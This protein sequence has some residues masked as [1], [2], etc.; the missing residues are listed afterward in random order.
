MAVMQLSPSETL[1]SPRLGMLLT[2]MADTPD[3]DTALNKVLADYLDLKLAS[4]SATR[5]AFEE[6]W[7]MSF[8]DFTEACQAETLSVDPYGYDVESDYWKWEAAETL[9]DHYAE[10]RQQWM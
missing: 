2:R 9:L 3:L 6:K 7:G 4:L 8:A 10:I 5:R 1:I